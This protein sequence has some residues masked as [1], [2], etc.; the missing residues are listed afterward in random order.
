MNVSKQEVMFYSALIAGF[1]ALSSGFLLD[2]NYRNTGIACALISVVAMM[3]L[4]L[5]YLDLPKTRE[6][7]HYGA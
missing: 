6:E 5:A 7:D 3:A 1:F 2:I 4:L